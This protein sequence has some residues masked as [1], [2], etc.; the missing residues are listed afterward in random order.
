MRLKAP[1]DKQ[2]YTIGHST[3]SIEDLI[4]LLKA[5]AV[6]KVID[7]RTVPK[8]RYCPQFNTENLKKSLK[9][10]RIGYRHMRDLGG[11]RHP[12]KDSINTGWINSAFRGFADYMQTAQF[13][14]ALEKLE[15]SAQ[16]QQCAL[17]C[18]EAIPWRCHRSLIAD[19]LTLRKWKVL[20]IQSKKTAKVHKRT[21]FL[22]VKRGV[23]FYP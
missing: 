13:K 9:L 2:I 18:A 5:H 12:S 15:K 8:S 10:E 17:M 22:K 7:I 14:K 3:R 16:K 6:K 1:K 19:P 20:H 4:A 23:L 11:F 21:P